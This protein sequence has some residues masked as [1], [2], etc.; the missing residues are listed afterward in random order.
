VGVVIRRK[1]KADPVTPELHDE[2]IARD[3]RYAGGCVAAFLQPEEH[4]CRDRWGTWR[5]AHDPAILTLDHVQNGYGRMGKRAASDPA[6]LVTLCYG[7]HLG[8]WA[9][10][11]RP[12]LREYLARANDADCGHVDPVFQCASCQRRSDPIQ[13]SETA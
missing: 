5:P 8:G 3:L 6:H 12:L 11:H 13:L 9:T 10:A 2:I 7:A 4:V 1:P